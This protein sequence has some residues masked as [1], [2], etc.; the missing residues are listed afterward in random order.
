M[1]RKPT[2]RV[3]A[4]LEELC[5]KYGYCLPPDDRDRLLAAPPETADAFADAVLIAEGL[6]LN[7]RDR[8]TVVEVICDWLF[9]EGSG[10]GT[11]SGLP[12]FD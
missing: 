9:E 2:S 8:A 7:G 6:D 3:D 10:R 12:M 4:A 5:V 1:G 11:R